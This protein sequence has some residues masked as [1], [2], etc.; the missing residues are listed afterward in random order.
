MK[1][2]S[3]P[4]FHVHRDHPAAPWL[5]VS[6]CSR[7]VHPFGHTTPS[8]THYTRSFS[9][10][11][12]RKWGKSVEGLR[13]DAFPGL[14]LSNQCWKHSLDILFSTTNRLIREETSLPFTPA[15]KINESKIR[16]WANCVHT[17]KARFP[18][19]DL[20]ARVDGWP[21]SIIPVNMGCVD[22]PSTRLVETRARQHGHVR[23]VRHA[24]HSRQH[25]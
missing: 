21:V 6:I 5:S 18:L 12:K 24:W 11:R 15:L 13:S 10:T 9:D 1:R 25:L 19:P 3:F 14:L 16:W 8:L 2:P 22:G 20:T 17:T 4:S 7:R 23:Q